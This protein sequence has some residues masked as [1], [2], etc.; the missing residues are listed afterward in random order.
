[1]AGRVGLLHFMTVRTF[2]ERWRSQVVMRAPLILASLGMTP[3]WVWHTNSS[4]DPRDVWG[5]SMGFTLGFL[6]L[7]E[8]V[9]L[10]ARQGCHSRV[11]SMRLAAALFAIEVGATVRAQAAAIPPADHLHRLGKIHCPGKPTARNKTLPSKKADFASV[12]RKWTLSF[13]CVGD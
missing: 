5:H 1:G 3:L 9:L 12:P 7:F 8:P 13:P 11:G 10:E 6:L 4:K 2:G